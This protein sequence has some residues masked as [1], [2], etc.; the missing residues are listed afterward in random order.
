MSVKSRALALALA[1]AGTIG[2][3]APMASA[4]TTSIAGHHG[5]I[6]N[7][8]VS[9]NN[10]PIAAGILGTATAGILSGSAGGSSSGSYYYQGSPYTSA[11]GCNC[12]TSTSAVPGAAVFPGG[13]VVVPPRASGGLFGY[14]VSRGLFGSRAG[15]GLLGGGRG[16][17]NA[18]VSNNNIPIA[19]A[20]LGT[21]TA[22]TGGLAGAGVL[23]LLSPAGSFVPVPGGEV[24]YPGGEVVPCPTSTP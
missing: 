14:R 8:N 23:G 4:A 3:S 24:I 15:G 12:G 2:L 1:T 9:N 17:I 7:V 11:A 22:G 16:L 13:E 18:N 20:I 21:A 6:L 10:I 19:A 5:G